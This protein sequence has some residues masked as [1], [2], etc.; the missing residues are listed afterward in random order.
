LLKLLAKCHVTES[1]TRRALCVLDARAQ[2][3]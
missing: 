1:D 3:T 2:H